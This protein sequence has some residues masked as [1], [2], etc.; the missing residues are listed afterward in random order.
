MKGAAKLHDKMGR[1]MRNGYCCGHLCKESTLRPLSHQV[2]N[3]KVSSA[4]THN[5][6]SPSEYLTVTSVLIFP[7]GGLAAVIYTDALQTLIMLI[8]ALILMGYS[9]WGPRVIWVDDN[10][11][12][13]KGHLLS[14]Q[15]QTQ[16]GIP[17]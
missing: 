17:A 10:T 15:F 4:T 11:S 1:H 14:S 2:L 5:N 7:L 12:L 3:F 16:L 8:G 6:S 13:K 9:K